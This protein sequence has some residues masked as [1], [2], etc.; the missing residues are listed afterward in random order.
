MNMQQVINKSFEFKQK[1]AQ[2][3]W[4]REGCVKVI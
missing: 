4:A 1:I 3:K 2:D